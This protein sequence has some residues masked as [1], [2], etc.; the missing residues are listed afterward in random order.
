MG[1]GI[2]DI[3]DFGHDREP[4]DPAILKALPRGC[5]V[6][7]VESHG[8]SFWNKIGRI[9]VTLLDGTSKS[10]FIKVFAWKN[11]KAAVEGEYAS[12]CTAHQAA[13]EF[14]TK[15]VGWGSYSTVPGAYFLICD[16]H[17]MSDEMPDPVA[18]A[19]HLVRLHRVGR[20]PEGKF[21]FPVT[22]YRGNLPQYVGWEDRWEVFFAKSMRFALGLEAKSRKSRNREFDLLA[23]VL[24]NV[25]IPRLLRPLESGGQ[26]ITPC[27]VHG[28][29]WYANSGVDTNNG[30]IRVF[31]L[32]S[33]YAHNEYEFGQWMVPNHR[34]GDEYIA[35]YRRFTT[36]S[37]PE[38]E[39][40]DRLDLYRLRFDIHALALYGTDTLREQ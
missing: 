25:V 24:V 7:S 16:F 14:V 22:T 3:P 1:L 4:L 19:S 37:E 31:G 29:L 39:F 32:S 27:L 34:F 12:L 38:D 6:Q 8:V 13:P 23:D 15:P 11:C 36:I 5:K 18:F 2:I 20:S 9:D 28:D 30:K 21:G 26:S 40:P 17:D 35:A 10:F 33:F